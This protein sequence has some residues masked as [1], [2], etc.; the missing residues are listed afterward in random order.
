M[1]SLWLSRAF[2]RHSSLRRASCLVLERL[3]VFS[4]ARKKPHFPLVAL[5]RGGAA[6]AQRG[7]CLPNTVCVVAT[8]VLGGVVPE[9]IG[10]ALI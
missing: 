8:T 1:N 9:N 6:D 10:H 5:L 2:A 4:C 3:L 7:E